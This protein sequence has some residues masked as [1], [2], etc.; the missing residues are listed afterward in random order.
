MKA[1]VQ[2]IYGGPNVLNFSEV[3]KP[4]PGSMD[5]LVKVKA[6]SVNPVDTK[7]R[8]RGEAGSRVSN[9]PQIL[10]WD[11]AGIVEETGNAVSNFAVGDAVYF[12]GDIGRQGCY[13]EYCLVDERIA[14]KKPSQLSF[15]EAA[16]IPLTALTGWEGL[17]EAMG[18]DEPDEGAGTLLLIGGAGGV[19]S[20]TTQIAKRVCGLEVIATASRDESE[21]FCRK[22]GADHV[23]NHR[24]PLLPQ[25]EKLGFKGVDYVF[26]CWE[27]DNFQ[28]LVDCLNPLGHICFILAGE[29]A[30]HLDLS[31]LF[32]IRGS[33]SFE[34]MFTRPRSG[35]SPEKQGQIL[36]RVGQLLDDGTLKTTM[37]EKFSW[38]EVQEVHHRIETHHTLGKLVMTVD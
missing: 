26:S 2:E 13:A 8:Q 3:P 16:A 38:S 32:M 30:K 21:E 34:F 6:V 31:R 12:A 20:I 11:A 27:L 7:M 5:L 25:L 36:N 22:M 28:Q 14:G 35:R 10:G 29:A 33:V 37:I 9:P 19:G 24:E 1:I 4:E 23:V 17:I 18:A 15:E